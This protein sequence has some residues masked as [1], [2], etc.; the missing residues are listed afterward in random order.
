M[1]TLACIVVLIFGTAQLS[2][3]L[4][5]HKRDAACFSNIDDPSRDTCFSNEAPFKTAQRNVPL[6]DDPRKY[7]LFYTLITKEDNSTQPL[8]AR[9][10]S[11]MTLSWTN[12]KN[13]LT[14][15]IIHGMVDVK[16]SSSSNQTVW[17]KEMAEELLIHDE[18]NVILV[19]WSNSST[20]PYEQAVSNA[21]V[22]GALVAQLIRTIK[23]VVGVQES[24]IH[25]IG[26]D[27]GAHVAG[28]VGQRIPGISRISGLDPSGKLFEDTPAEVRLDTSDATFVDVIHT[29]I[30]DGNYTRSKKIITCH[31][32]YKKKSLCPT[33][34][35]FLLMQGNFPDIFRTTNWSSNRGF[36]IVG[37]VGHMDFYPNLGYRQPGCKNETKGD[38]PEFSSCD[39]RRA[40]ELFIASINTECGFISFP[41]D[42]A[43]DYV[44]NKCHPCGERG[45]APMG[46]NSALKKSDSDQLVKYYLKTSDEKPYCL[47]HLD[48][49][50]KVR[51]SGDDS[52]ENP[53]A[54]NIFA[55]IKGDEQNTTEV[56]LRKE[57][58]Y[59][60]PGNS[61]N[62]TVEFPDHQD[63][64][65][66]VELRLVDLEPSSNETVPANV[67][68]V[69]D[70]V[71][72][73]IETEPFGLDNEREL[74][75]E[76]VILRLNET[77]IIS[78][79]CK[80]AY[81]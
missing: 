57:P 67:T 26:Y 1:V 4:S 66:S 9:D 33:K 74:C 43:E 17:M 10:L 51:E 21:R 6:P 49:T 22:M 41:C 19:D 52:S 16:N 39:H 48:F 15:I 13:R 34:M 72:I 30:D 18:S 59:F 71:S 77:T 60:Q 63:K 55:S 14:T 24:N 45:C 40:Y 65:R 11:N 61:Y 68:L 54:L 47:I 78:K 7:G 73:K 53:Q 64:I 12:I 76:N 32:L 27:L 46:Y 35:K 81:N 38:G 29:D 36:G 23:Q 70:L 62:F 20:S 58:V 50:L 75:D 25:I 37:P 42:S 79:D 56:P 5:R 31:S 69:L 2:A 44:S 80:S 3:G 28:Y 8:D